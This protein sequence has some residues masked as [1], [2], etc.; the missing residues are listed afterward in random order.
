[1][2]FNLSALWWRKIRGLWKLPNGRDWLRGKLGL[3]LMGRAIFS[4]SLIHF[5]VL[6]GGA[7]FS[8]SLIQFSVGN[9][10]DHMDHIWSQQSDHTLSNSMK[11]WAMLCRVTQGI[12]VMVD[13][14]E[15][16]WS[17]GEGDRKPLQYFCLENPRNTMKRQKDM[18]LKDELPRSVGAQ[19]ATGNEWRNKSRKNEE[20]EP[21]QK[22]HLVVDV[23]GD[24]SKVRCCKQQYCIS[25]VQF[26]SVSQSCPTLCDPMNHSTP[27]LPVHHQLLDFT[28]SH[29]HRVGDSIQPSHPLSSRSPPAPNPS[30]YQGLFQWVNSSHE[31]TKVLEFQLQHQSFQCTPR[32][33]C[34]QDGLVGVQG[35]LKS[36]LKQHCPKASIFWH[37]TFF[38]IQQSIQDHWKNHSLD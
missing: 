18:T 38:I 7:A 26:S 25:S 37:S 6:M 2:I 16:T 1:M 14:S 19:Y 20:T 3:V 8:K 29:A 34:L 31:V 13:S 11:L 4:K 36:F 33:Y 28:Q 10:F 35:T 5:S 17:T 27:G 12:W 21:K 30:Q 15:K 9:C 23:T 32:T 22:Q 24:E